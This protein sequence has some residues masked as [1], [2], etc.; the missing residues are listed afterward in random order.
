MYAGQVVETGVV[1]QIFERP[2]HPYTRG[3]MNCLPDSAQ[4]HLEHLPSIR[5]TVPSL[6]GDLRGCRFRDRCDF[7]H[8]QCQNDVELGLRGLEQAPDAHG[9]V[10]RQLGRTL[11]ERGRRGQPAAALRAVGGACQLGGHR[12]VR[13]RGRVRVVPGTAVRVQLGVGRF[14]ECPES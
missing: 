7:A 13:R 12:F 6:V 1:E 14:R 3:L 9:R 2:L 8:A 5:G 11:Q 4:R 10:R